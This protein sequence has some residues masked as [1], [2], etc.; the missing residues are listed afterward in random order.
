MPE[1][2]SHPDHY[3]DIAVLPSPNFNAQVVLNML[4]DKLHLAFV[5]HQRGD[6]GVSFP[7]VLE[8][9]VSLGSLIRLHGSLE[10][11]R[12]FVLKEWAD[13]VGEFISISEIREVPDSARHVKVNRVQ[14]KSNA[15]RLRRRYRKR[16]PEIDAEEVRELIPDSV[17]Q[18]VQLPYLQVQSKSSGE[19]FRLFV[20]HQIC[21][22]AETT[23]AFSKYGLSAGSTVPWF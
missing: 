13:G 20:K 5:E 6:I 22:E 2:L 1:L 4:F 19:H 8:D 3:A 12:E 15:A 7:E 14:V 10:S 21:E 23:K 17:E 11:L 16:H 9:L 18:L